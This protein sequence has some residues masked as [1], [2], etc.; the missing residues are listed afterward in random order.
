MRDYIR[1]PFEVNAF[2]EGIVPLSAEFRA[3]PPGGVPP[4]SYRWELVDELSSR[5]ESATC[6]VHR[7]GVTPRPPER[8]M[9]H[10]TF[11]EARVSRSDGLHAP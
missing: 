11:I 9:H 1:D 10:P 8:L 6:V 5:G 7:L 2:A 3:E 4:F